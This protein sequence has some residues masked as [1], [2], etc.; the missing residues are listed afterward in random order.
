VETDFGFHIIKV[1]EAK[2]NVAYEIA[3]I[4]RQIVPSDETLNASYRKAEAFADD[5][6][7]VEEF[8]QRAKEQ[9]L[10]VVEGK[11]VAAGDRRVGAL[12]DARQ[13]VQ[14]LYRDAKVGS[15][16]EIFDLQD[17]HVVAVM[18][19]EIEA[20][21]KPLETVKDE[22]TSSVRNEKN[23]KI[24]INK[25][26][27]LNG[28]LEEIAKA[29][30]PDA[31]IYT[32]SDLKLSSNALPSAGYD[33]KAVGLAFGIENGKRSAPV[34]GE[35]GVI[36]MEPINR[37]VAPELQDY[38]AYKTQLQ[39]NALNMSSLSIAEAIKENSDIEDERYK[40][41]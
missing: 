37:T 40:Y 8:E 6:S 29:Y 38:S 18:T 32:S 20:G 12:S 26:K 7:G 13:I 15:V 35:N 36:L 21:Y 24:I 27:G 19:G 23:G 5:L 30:G 14:W 31:N 3:I 33:P 9:K 17:Q 10:T 39:E 11:G 34:A 41:Y 25:L 1:T 2:S 22:I 4:E 28:T 16:S